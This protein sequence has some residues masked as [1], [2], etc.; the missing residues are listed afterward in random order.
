[1]SWLV[2]PLNVELDETAEKPEEA[3][4]SDEPTTTTDEGAADK[5]EAIKPFISQ[6][7]LPKKVPF[8]SI[9]LNGLLFHFCPLTGTTSV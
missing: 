1:M 9:K 2:P 6:A 4:T 8:F 3:E 7:P 5:T